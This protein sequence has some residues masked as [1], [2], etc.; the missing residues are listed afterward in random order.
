MPILSNDKTVRSNTVQILKDF[1]LQSLSTQLEKGEQIV[2]LMP[3]MEK[4]FDLM[5]DGIKR[6]IS[7]RRIS[8]K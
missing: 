2:S 8:G 7:R 1:N 3:A 4:S 6:I 5:D